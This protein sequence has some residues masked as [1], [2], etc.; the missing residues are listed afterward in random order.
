MRGSDGRCNLKRD[1]HSRSVDP[2]GVRDR[3]RALL[4][5]MGAPRASIAIMCAAFVVGRVSHA[6]GL[7][8]KTTYNPVRVG[9]IVLTSIVGIGLGWRL[10]SSALSHWLS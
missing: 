6:V 8:M 4:E 1:E 9:G 2:L 3:T 7:S 10:V 5:L